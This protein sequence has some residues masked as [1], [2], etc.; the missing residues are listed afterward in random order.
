MNLKAPCPSV[1]PGML[2][3]ATLLML[4]SACARPIGALTATELLQAGR[5]REAWST[6][7][8]DADP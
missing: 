4:L 6:L 2:R 5:P 3:A 8:R 1:R 7:A